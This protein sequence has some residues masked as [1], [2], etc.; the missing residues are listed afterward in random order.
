[1]KSRTPTPLALVTFSIVFLSAL[2]SS[3]ASALSEPQSQAQQRGFKT[4]EEG[5][6]RLNSPASG[7]YFALVIGNNEYQFEPKLKTAVNDAEAVAKVL[8][9][10]YGF[11]TTVLLNATRAQIL[12]AINGY[13]KTLD[14][15]AS[16]LIYYAGH[17]YRDTA[18]DLA[19]W[20]PVDAALDD[21][22]NWITA[23]DITSDIKVLAA[24][25][26]LIVSDSCDSGVLA[27]EAVSAQDKAVSLQKLLENP[28]RSLMASG[29]LEPVS[30]AGGNGHSIFATAFLS[31]LEANKD[32]AFPATSLFHDY[33]YPVVSGRSSQTPLY[34]SIRNAGTDKGDFVFMHPAGAPGS[35]PAPVGPVQVAADAEP[36][37]PAQPYHY[38]APAPEA[39]ALE[40]ALTVLQRASDMLPT[41]DIGQ[42]LA[43]ESMIRS[44][45]SFGGADLSGLSLK[46][47]R[48]D[49]GDFSKATMA[50]ADLTRVSA[51]SADFTQAD[52]AFASLK[53]AHF[54]GATLEGA[55]LDY[56]QAERT[57]FQNSKASAIRGFSAVARGSDFT[58]ANLNGARF[59]FA[60]FRDARFDGADL[61][62]AY[63][64]GCD[65]TG[66]SFKKAKLVNTDFTGSVIDL[67]ALDAQQKSGACETP[68][69]DKVA[70]VKVVIIDEIPSSRFSGG[71][72]HN[73]YVDTQYFVNVRDL[74]LR[75]CAIRQLQKS[76]WY[77]I[78]SA[79]GKEYLTDAYGSGFPSK[80]IDKPGRRGGDISSRVEDH[81]KWL[82]SRLKP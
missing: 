72:E 14:E 75:P 48:F 4:V 67:K 27:R 53:E 37:S 24:R 68:V 62:G 21:N 57:Q 47:G 66:A 5:S 65:L 59:M 11:E 10:S 2:L 63:F 36:R 31:G 38:E 56:A 32:P 44:R 17:G 15:N 76:W 3:L 70:E 52:L 80:L 77:P 55:K 81:Y 60:D 40:T 58:Q 33:V 6:P 23:T 78:F 9:S 43:V 34:T 64:V 45:H 49:S 69:N 13:R 82:Q 29:S 20:L 73:R 74:G 51:A 61:T 79:N 42:V 39:M 8:R 28:S 30:D 1:M 46:G 50:D 22:S 54:E 25:H 35:S 18:N 16:L 26:V 19:Y 71:I 41:G 12:G 7:P